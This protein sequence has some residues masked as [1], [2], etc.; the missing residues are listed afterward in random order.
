MFDV[1]AAAVMADPIKS[2]LGSGGIIGLL[3][4]LLKWSRNRVKVRGVFLREVY[5]VNGGDD[6]PTEVRIELENTGRESTSILPTVE[7]SFV[8]PHRNGER[9]EIKLV[10]SDRTLPPVTPREL[11]L[12]GALP[13]GYL[14][15]HFRVLT[16]RFTRGAPVKL[17]ILNASG[18]SAGFVRFNFLKYFYLIT[19]KLPHIKA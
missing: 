4:I 15:S 5:N 1:I 14:F 10:T 11:L 3:A 6:V 16:I 19:G 2:I 7:V 18:Q 17:R 9:Q 12:R 13:P 8:Y